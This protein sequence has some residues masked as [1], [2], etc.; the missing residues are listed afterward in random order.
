MA[1]AI[2]IIG[3]ALSIFMFIRTENADER[4]ARETLARH[5]EE[6][7]RVVA[8]LETTGS[9]Q[10]EALEGLVRVE[11]HRHPGVSSTISLW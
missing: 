9:Q 5:G 8:D 6:L 2:A 4:R 7:T 1:L 10:A 11:Q 3:I